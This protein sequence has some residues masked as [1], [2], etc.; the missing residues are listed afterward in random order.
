MSRPPIHRFI[1]ASAPRR[2]GSRVRPQTNTTLQIENVLSMSAMFNEKAQNHQSRSNKK[3]LQRSKRSPTRHRNP[4]GDEPLP[5]NLEVIARILGQIYEPFVISERDPLDSLILF[6]LSTQTTSKGCLQSFDQL[7]RDYPHFPE[8]AR[9]Q[10]VEIAES[11]RFGGLADQKA[12]W[13]SQILQRVHER[14]GTHSLDAL[15]ALSDDE[16]EAF[17]QQMPGVGRKVARCVL[18]FRFGRLVFPVDTHIW[19]IAQRLG[20]ITASRPGASCTPRHMDHLQKRIPPKHRPALH[21]HLVQFG[22]EVCQAQQPRCESCPI[23]DHC[24]KI[25]ITPSE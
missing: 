1:V 15:Q 8:L 4:S 16:A 14:F 7:K 9:A 17:L 3:P 20:W 13:I 19:R 6:V 18:M 5:P 25:G 11:I 12:R 23:Q 2:S 22:R 24:P 21:I 10:P